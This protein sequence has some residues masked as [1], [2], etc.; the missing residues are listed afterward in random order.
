MREKLAEL[1]TEVE[2]RLAVRDDRWKLVAGVWAVALAISLLIALRLRAVPRLAVEAE[3]E[4]PAAPEPEPQVE[5]AESERTE[6]L[7]PM[8][9]EERHD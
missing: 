4:V 7:K 3:G 8:R 6:L 2:A 5:P 9:E 1:G